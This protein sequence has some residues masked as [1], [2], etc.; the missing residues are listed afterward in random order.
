MENLTD[1][2]YYDMRWKEEEENRLNALA[3]LDKSDFEIVNYKKYEMKNLV[4]KIRKVVIYSF[5]VEK[6]DN[7]KL[8]LAYILCAQALVYEETGTVIDE[9]NLDKGEIIESCCHNEPFPGYQ[10]LIRETMLT[11]VDLIVKITYTSQFDDQKIN[12]KL[13]GLY[14]SENPYFYNEECFDGFMT[15]L[16]CTTTRLLK[17]NLGKIQSNAEILKDEGVLIQ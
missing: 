5:A 7:D 6:L 4:N 12:E 11:L 1:D 10:L 13:I 14:E 16:L 9:I 8:I 2:E 17:E 3:L 15:W